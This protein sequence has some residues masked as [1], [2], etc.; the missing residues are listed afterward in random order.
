M[1]GRVFFDASGKTMLTGFMAVEG[2]CEASQ[3]LIRIWSV[4]KGNMIV[5][6]LI[7]TETYM[8]LKEQSVIE[9]DT[10]FRNKANDSLKS[11]DI[12][13]CKY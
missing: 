11:I 6:N 2:I 13:H 4:L 7:G 5:L 1:T 10:S 9:P 8:P 12:Q 3:D